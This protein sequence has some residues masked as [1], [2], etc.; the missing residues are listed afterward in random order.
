VHLFLAGIRHESIFSLPQRAN[1][2]LMAVISVPPVPGFGHPE[3]VARST[4]KRLWLRSSSRR[5]RSLRDPLP[6]IV[7]GRFEATKNRKLSQ[8]R[9]LAL[10]HDTRFNRLR[11]VP[12]GPVT[13]AFS[14]IYG[15]ASA[16]GHASPLGL[17]RERQRRL[18]IEVAPPLWRAHVHVGE[19]LLIVD[20]H[21]ILYTLR[22]EKRRNYRCIA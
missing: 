22:P 2:R 15:K 4:T 5:R 21:P 12:S 13:R 19:P 17:R 14:A 11:N 8:K 10:T 6:P 1:G 20:L 7:N 18:R 16:L 3:P 9:A